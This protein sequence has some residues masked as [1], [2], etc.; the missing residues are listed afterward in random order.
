MPFVYILTNKPFGTLYT[1]FTNHLSTRIEQH[2]AQL[3]DGFTKE[4]D[5][6]MLVWYEMHDSNNDI[7][8]TRTRSGGI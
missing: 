3:V 6:H 5:L 7:T 2:Q 8:A 4:H 1:G